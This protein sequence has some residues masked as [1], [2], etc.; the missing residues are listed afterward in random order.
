MAW[1]ISRN[2]RPS[3]APPPTPAG[4]ARSPPRC[5]CSP[6][7]PLIAAAYV[8]Y[9]LWPR[10]PDAPVALDAPS[11]PIDRRRRLLQHR[12]GGD[13][14]VGA[15]PPGHAGARR[16]R[17]SVAV[18]AAARS[19]AQADA[20]RAGRSQRAAVRH[21]PDRR[22]HAAAASNACRRSIRAIWWPSRSPALP[23]D[24]ARFP[25]RHALSGRGAGV[26][27]AARRSISWRAARAK[28]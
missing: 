2:S 17:L 19:R 14:H 5:C 4:A 9:V 13:P 28:A 23:A 16:P 10:W 3:A 7:R 18:A 22:R 24:A 8:A 15:A 11:L 25:R 27:I 21:H 26:R 6:P 12:A 20:R 1:P